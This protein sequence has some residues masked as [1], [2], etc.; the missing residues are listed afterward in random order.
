M[1][2]AD[3]CKKSIL[4][5]MPQFHSHEKYILETLEKW[6]ANVVSIQENIRTTRLFY[7]FFWH[8]SK[9]IGYLLLNQ[10]Y[11]HKLKNVTDI[12]IVL[13]IKGESVSEETMQ[14][15]CKTYPESK[16]ILYQWDSTSINP[17]SL[18]IMKY[19]D[20]VASFDPVDANQYG[21]KYRPLFFE[22]PKEKNHR[23]EERYDISFIGT[24]HTRRIQVFQQAKLQAAQKDLKL[25]GYL[26]SNFWTY[27]VRKF[28][29]K[30]ASF[31]GL[32]SKEIHYK[33]L[34]LKETIK[35]YCSSKVILDYA[36]PGQNGLTMRT[37]EA[38]CNGCKLLTN[39]KGICNTSLFKAD[40]VAF[41]NENNLEIPKDFCRTPFDPLGEDIVEYY[42][43][44][45]WLE[46]LMSYLN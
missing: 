20:V 16:K 15:I 27:N 8:L 44:E 37:I 1:T 45:Y 4:L 28:I 33:P 25:Y 38:L 24:L 18:V 17:Q 2:K 6:G 34:P 19:F 35:I 13:V 39:N 12:D 42:T 9:K 43:L 14:S 5:I 30:D 36:A 40:N 10:Y 3:I 11:R 29:K 7:K 22:G 32:N 26:Y 21:W 23:K 41:Y 46:E 31:Q